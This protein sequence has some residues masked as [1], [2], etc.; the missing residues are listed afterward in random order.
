MTSPWALMQQM[1]ALF[2][3]IIYSLQF[4]N[5]SCFVVGKIQSTYITR[6]RVAMKIY[7]I[8]INVIL[9]LSPGIPLENT[10]ML[11]V[12]CMIEESDILCCVCFLHLFQDI[13]EQVYWSILYSTQQH[14]S[15]VHIT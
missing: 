5:N 7:D 4:N 13:P 12:V 3:L 9:F 6:N 10:R 2:C 8:I 11:S 14:L 15:H 1:K